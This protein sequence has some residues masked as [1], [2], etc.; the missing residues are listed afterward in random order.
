MKY[1]ALL[2]L[3]WLC[4]CGYIWSGGGMIYCSDYEDRMPWWLHVPKCDP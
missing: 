4:G 1:V 2:M 3:L